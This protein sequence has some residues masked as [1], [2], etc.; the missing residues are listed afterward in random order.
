MIYRELC[1]EL[2]SDH[3]AKWYLHKPESV[4]ENEIQKCLGFW[5]T[6]ISS[7]LARKPDHMQIKKEEKKKRTCCIMNSAVPVDHRVKIKGNEK[8]DTYW[9]LA[10]ELKQLWNMR[11]TIITIEIGEIWTER[12]D[13]ERGWK[14]WKLEDESRPFDLLHMVE[15]SQNK[16]S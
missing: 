7:N 3:T 16:Y 11:I 12:N 4:I 15:I 13:F 2:K 6:E 5:V 10:R 14:S 9:V 8:R 1:K